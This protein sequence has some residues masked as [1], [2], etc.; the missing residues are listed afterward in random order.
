MLC[1]MVQGTWAEELTKKQALELA[2]QFV[3]SHISAPDNGNA[4]RGNIRQTAPTINEAGQ[5]SGLYVFNV[6]DDGGFVIVSNDDRTVPILGFGQKGNI[7][8]DNMPDNMRAWLQ[9][10]ADQ[11]EWLKTVQ[12]SKVQGSKNKAAEPSGKIQVSGAN[13]KVDIEPLIT[14]K[15]DQDKPYNNLC[16]EIDGQR[17]ITGCAATAIAQIMNYH[18]WPKDACKPIP[19]YD[20]RT[21][22][23]DKDSISVT[24]DGIPATTFDWE[25]IIDIYVIKDPKGKEQP[26]Y[27]GNETQ[28]HAIAELM[29]YSGAAM[30]MQ[31]ELPK[32]GSGVTGYEIAYAM[33]TYFGYDSGI[34]Y[35]LRKY[36]T[37]QDW[38]DL[39]YNELAENRPVL[40]CGLS[41][42]GGHAFVCDGYKF[43]DDA[44]YFSINWGWS[45]IYDNYFLLSLLNP[46]EK[47]IGGRS[48]LDGFVVEQFAL[49]GIQPSVEGNKDFGLLLNS[50]CLNK[51]DSCLT[52]KTFSRKKADDD[53]KDINIYFQ[54]TS[55]DLVPMDY[56]IALQLVDGSGNVVNTLE[57]FKEE[58]D[59]NKATEKDVSLAIPSTLGDGTYYIKVTCRPTGS[60]KWMECHLGNRQQLTAD[61]SD[62]TLT[63]EVPLP[64]NTYPA[65]TLSVTG[66][67][68]K[69]HEQTVTA[70][71]SDGIYNGDI[72]LFVNDKFIM[73]QELNLKAGE[74][75]ELQF[76]FIPNEAGENT[77]ALYNTYKDN[78]IQI[79]SF[80][81]TYGSYF[82]YCLYPAAGMCLYK[83]LRKKGRQYDLLAVLLLTIAYF[84]AVYYSN[85]YNS[86]YTK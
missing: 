37:Y 15:W 57:T 66:D 1:T 64:K 84:L 69:G 62:N 53:F 21:V 26:E 67:M 16:P 44:D 79:G 4:A 11:I 10:Y 65:A 5:V 49:T 25:N 63:I 58:L 27:F 72:V 52:S 82:S 35:C 20:Y 7:D 29:Q 68:K 76:A 43:K 51:E 33:K 30:H 77:L 61:I 3:A 38:V 18:K 6:S 60:D 81:A 59:W 17:S 24:V 39:I 80:F 32:L 34:E 28:Q 12:G 14:T 23:T 55:C 8:P 47:G 13:A 9:G 42:G 45:G 19:S 78:K 74:T 41:A 75:V 2:K 22:N 56:D 40:L 85:S 70:T 48:S 46:I 54:T 36:Y 50:L 83:G 31:Y 73:G 86:Y 71:F